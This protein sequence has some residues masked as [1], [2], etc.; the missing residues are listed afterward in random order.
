MVRCNESALNNSYQNLEIICVD[1][2]STDHSLEILRSYE[3]KDSRIIVIAKENGGVSSARNASLDQVTGEY[4]N[5]VDPDDY[6]HPQYFELLYCA[7]ALTGA[8]VVVGGFELFTDNQVT[9]YPRYMLVPEEIRCLHYSDFKN[10][11]EIHN[12]SWCKL[13]S[14]EII[15]NTRFH[16]EFSYAEDTVFLLELWGKHP[17]IQFALF[18]F[19]VYYYYQGRPDSLVNS[20][21]E[22]GVLPYI[23]FLAR[24]S[25]IIVKEGV[26]RD[27][28]LN[29]V[30]II[31]IT[32][33][34]FIKSRNS[35]TAWHHS[36]WQ[37]QANSVFQDGIQEAQVFL[38]PVHSLLKS[39]SISSPVSKSRYEKI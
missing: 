14:R 18:D 30:C 29:A 26:Y 7:H 11:N 8:E 17:L 38:D 22:R 20:G 25:S 34:S 13:F 33:N 12:Y 39:R 3:A 37:N 5:F 16:D 15:G 1:D 2:G 6:I 31:A 36:A 19:P 21:R 35:K 32:S 23:S 28:Q 9:N 24:Q 27:P 10:Y 4:V